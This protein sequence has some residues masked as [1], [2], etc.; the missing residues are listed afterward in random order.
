MAL[1]VAELVDADAAQPLQAFRVEAAPITR[2]TIEPT[3]AQAL[4]VRMP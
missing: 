1:A 2:S 4:S 3:V